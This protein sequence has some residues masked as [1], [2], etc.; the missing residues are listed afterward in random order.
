MVR[1]FQLKESNACVLNLPQ[2]GFEDE[3]GLDQLTSYK[4]LSDGRDILT[5]KC[6]QCHSAT[7][8]EN[9]PPATI[10]GVVGLVTRMV[11]N[12]LAG[13]D[14]ELAWIMRYLQDKHVPEGALAAS[15]STLKSQSN[16]P[17]TDAGDS[18]SSDKY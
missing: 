1:I 7:L 15:S 10:D 4:G 6:T 16:D 12:G 5:K 14:Q 8:V 17:T 9:N 2:I 11:G 3:A 13:S 18:Y